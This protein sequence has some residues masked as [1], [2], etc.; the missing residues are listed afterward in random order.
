MTPR[1]VSLRGLSLAEAE[2]KVREFVAD[3]QAEA[4]EHFEIN[5]IDRGADPDDLAAELARQR[6]EN[7]QMREQA[8]A[9]MRGMAERDGKT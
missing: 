2:V 1:S 8:I 3:V 7:V 6:A 9:K 4:L 5:M